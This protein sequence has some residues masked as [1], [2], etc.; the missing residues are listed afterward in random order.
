ITDAL[1]RRD[2]PAVGIEIAGYLL[3]VLW[4]IAAVLSGSGHSN[5]WFETL[6][7]AVYGVGGILFLAFV[8][9]VGLRLFLSSH[10][11]QAIQEG[12]VAAGIVAAGSYIATGSI[13]SGAVAGEGSG[14]I[15]TAIVFFVVGQV[16]FVVITYLFRFL[17]AY[18]DSEEILNGNIP[19]ALSYA[20]VM[21]AVGIIVGNAVTGD[22]VD[23]T[24]SF[25]AFGKALL[26]VLALYPI[27]Q[28][29]VQGLLLGGGFRLYGGSLDEEISRD[30]NTNAGLIEATTYIAT[31]LLVT[32]LV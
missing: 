26:I 18:R 23:Y 30:H 31:A 9:T 32:R 2:N 5:L 17:T 11:L 29:L 14:T 10:S 27:R 4:I 28:W 20:G 16:A 22:F 8:A 19:A 13:I 6:E 15:V 25:V 3:G 24:T 1:I 7:V 12:N 21:T